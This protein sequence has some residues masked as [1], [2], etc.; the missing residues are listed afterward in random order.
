MRIK[1]QNRCRHENHK[2]KNE[3][4][5]FW[6]ALLHSVLAFQSGGTGRSEPLPKNWKSLCL[7]PFVESFKK[8]FGKLMLVISSVWQQLVFANTVAMSLLF[9]AIFIESAE[10]QH[11][12]PI[13]GENSCDLQSARLMKRRHGQEFRM[14]SLPLASLHLFL[15]QA[16]QIEFKIDA[17]SISVYRHTAIQPGCIH[18]CTMH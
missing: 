6:L 18:K 7:H 4:W 13:F 5:N 16:I 3:H 15:G 12:F 8:D 17:G 14:P 2:A 10:L 9:P 11:G 1:G